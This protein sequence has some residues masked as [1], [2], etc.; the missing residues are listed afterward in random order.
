MCI[1]GHIS[2]TNLQKKMCNNPKLDLVFVN[3]HTEGK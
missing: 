2:V 1:E 3:V